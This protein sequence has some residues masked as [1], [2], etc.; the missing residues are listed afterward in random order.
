M[1]P[2][3]CSVQGE[4]G[5]SKLGGGGGWWGV[6]T[7]GGQ[8]LDAVPSHE[9]GSKGNVCV[10]GVQGVQG[11]SKRYRPVR[12][13][14]LGWGVHTWAGRGLDTV[15]FLRKL[16]ARAVYKGGQRP[17]VLGIYITLG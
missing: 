5:A 13:D 4:K 3:S 8:I 9:I 10:Q 16:V 6:H 17:P 15:P 7:W 14:S 11:V 12:P 1:R 2:D